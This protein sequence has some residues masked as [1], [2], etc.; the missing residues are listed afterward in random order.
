MIDGRR[1]LFLIM[2]LAIAPAAF[3]G[4]MPASSHD[5]GAL[6]PR[7]DLQHTNASSLFDC[8]GASGLHFWLGQ[9]SPDTPV[10]VQQDG[11]IQHPQTLTDDT[12]SL[13]L[14]LSA[15][16]G[17]G[18]CGSVHWVKKG[19]FHFVPDWY[20]NG[21]PFQIGHSHAVMPNCLYP[22]PAYCFIQPAGTAENA[23]AQYRLGMVLSLWRKSQFTPTVLGS[24]APPNMS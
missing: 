17:L 1:V 14:C 20:H 8:S 24:R 2:G 10:E 12:G 22:V 21:G 3:A 11:Q 4:M 6:G 15:L 7:T 23:I 13:S 5:V 19:S 9:L 16:I 18:L